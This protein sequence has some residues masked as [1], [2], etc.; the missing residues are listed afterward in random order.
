MN[1][2]KVI[3]LNPFGPQGERTQRPTVSLQDAAQKFQGAIAAAGLGRPEIEADGRIHRFDLPDESRGKKS[4]WYIL[5]PDNN[6][7]PAGEF[8]NWK[9]SSSE[10]WNASSGEG[11]YLT[12]E[13]HE[14]LQRKYALAK[15]HR[16]EERRKA[17]IAAANRLYALYQKLPDAT[18]H[19]CPY[20][21]KKNIGAFGGVKALR[22]TLCVPMLDS[23]FRFSGMQFIPAD[24]AGKKFGRDVSWKGL[25]NIL[26]GD[27]STVY[28]CE[29]YATGASV[30]MATG[31][32]VVVVFTADNIMGVAKSIKSLGAFQDSKIIIAADDDQWT[33]RPNGTPWN[34]GLEKAKEAG[35]KL[36]IQVVQPIF[37]DLSTRPTDFNDLHALEGID[38][39]KLQITAKNIGPK[40]AD[41]ESMAAFTG[42]PP[43][44]EWLVRGVF[45]RGQVSLIAAA[46]GIGKSFLLLS[47]ARDVASNNL[48]KPA[49][50]GGPIELSGS[51]VYLSAEDDHI[52]I[53]GRLN[54][55]GG[56]VK[57]FYAV[58]LPSAGGAK[59]YF[60]AI[61]K[62]FVTTDA[63]SALVA[64]LRT[65][66][67]L[68]TLIIDPI[69]PLCAMDL[70]MP[71]AA[72]AV[73]SFLADLAADLNV[74]VIVA[75]HFRKSTVTNTEEARNAIRGTAGLVDGVRSVY[76]LWQAPEGDTKKVCKKLGVPI[77]EDAVVYGCVVKGNGQKL[78][79]VRKFIRADHGA[80][81]DMTNELRDC[82]DDDTLLI[83]L[84]E[85]IAEAAEDGKPY[86][87]TGANGLYDRRTEL[88]EPLCLMAR[89]KLWDLAETLMASGDVRTCSA[90]GSK[91]VKWLDVTDG[92][93]AV[94][95]GEF[96][97]GFFSASEKSIE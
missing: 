71:E 97:P 13:D 94:G 75:H 31:A 68:T 65:I 62:Q 41:W 32:S 36:G 92:P 11:Y 90:K 19:T 76:A 15:Q 8:G 95:S 74:S 7:C 69:Q 55:L 27:N 96:A 5:Y 49:H 57:G 61:E 78:S 26:H 23:E 80:L 4:G 30:H 52:E 40:L 14:A 18:Q 72:Q 43:A 34:P 91:T 25:F 59:P 47:M 63:W 58:P 85:I 53:H 2:A 44:R 73:C 79:G 45:P 33:R 82:V 93:F 60:Q 67:N 64:Q 35:A 9:D 10:T 66:R 56:P 39:V 87:K 29:G 22:G 24:G 84:K 16:E 17:A 3:D 6:P 81:V 86:T 46:G 38:A 20:L 28:L 88:P 50:F 51:S 89:G 37:K 48:I 70:N 42:E 83:A 12:S 1:V 77:K 54:S 21:A